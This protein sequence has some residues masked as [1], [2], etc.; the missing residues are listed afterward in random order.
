MIILTQIVKLYSF[1]K[2]VFQL[3][4]C[5]NSLPDDIILDW[6]KLKLCA[7]CELKTEICYGI[8]RKHCGKRRKCWLPAFSVF[9]T[10]FSKAFHFFKG[11]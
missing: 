6:S 11:R 2:L 9:P 5:L 4:A 3:D 8:S 7:E 1:V 10:M